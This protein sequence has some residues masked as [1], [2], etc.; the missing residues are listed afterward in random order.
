MP[1]P[2]MPSPFAIT[3]LPF[4]LACLSMGV[5]FG[6]VN[7]ILAAR[8]SRPVDV[9]EESTGVVPPRGKIGRWL[10]TRGGPVTFLLEA[11]RLSTSLALLSLSVYAVWRFPTST[12]E[13]PQIAGTIQ[14]NV[15]VSAHHDSLAG[16]F[17]IL[18]H[19]LS[20][21]FTLQPSLSLPS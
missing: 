7:R 2:S 14:V 21:S 11:V 5:F 4:W 6:T 8:T 1:D 18:I 16:L 20:H 15:F 17:L 12:P 9:L 3:T 10:A 19:H 13:D